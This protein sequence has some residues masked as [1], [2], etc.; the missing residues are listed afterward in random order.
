[1]CTRPDYSGVLISGVDKYKF[2]LSW[3]KAKCSDY[4]RCPD[5]RMATF[6]GSTVVCCVQS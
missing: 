4:T 5:F 1:M 2:L 6:G 3:A